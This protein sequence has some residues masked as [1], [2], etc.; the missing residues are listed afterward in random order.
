MTLPPAVRSWD[1]KEGPVLPKSSAG[2]RTIPILGV[3]RDRLDEHKLRTG[4]DGD[5]LVFGRDTETPFAPKST[6]ERAKRSWKA[7][8]LTGLTMHE[9]RHTCASLM[10]A[11]GVNAKALSTYLGHATIAM[12]FDIYGHLMPGNREEARELMDAYLERATEETEEETL[13]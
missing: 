11:A 12:T 7:A 3:L 10:I 8:G 1:P 5:A 13:A 4:R 2:K 6:D 9:A